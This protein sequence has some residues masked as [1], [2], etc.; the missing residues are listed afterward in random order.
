MYERICITH[1]LS[2]MH[3]HANTEGRMGEGT[4][5]LW[6]TGAEGLRESG[7]EGRRVWGPE[8]QN[9]IM[10]GMFISCTS[11]HSC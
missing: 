10:L 4:E 6:G 8:G 7:V 9:G 1:S 5:G 2:Y 3:T 11:V